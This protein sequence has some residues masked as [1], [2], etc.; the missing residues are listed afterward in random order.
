MQGTRKS[1]C[2]TSIMGAVQEHLLA[3]VFLFIQDPCFVSEQRIYSSL[4]DDEMMDSSVHRQTLQAYKELRLVDHLQK[5]HA[6]GQIYTNTMLLFFEK[7][8]LHKKTL[9]DSARKKIH[10]QSE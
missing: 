8:T 5:K 9:T 10:K 7:L 3:E 2:N 4:I 1:A 6:I